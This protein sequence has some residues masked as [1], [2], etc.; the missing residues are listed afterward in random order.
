MRKKE[1]RKN[2]KQMLQVR[3]H[4]LKH[5][6]SLQTPARVIERTRHLILAT[7]TPAVIKVMILHNLQLK[8]AKRQVEA[9]R[10][11]KRKE[12]LRKLRPLAVIIRWIT[13]ILA[14]VMYFPPRSQKLWLRVI[15][16]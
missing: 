2:T 13:P 15:N 7:L 3:S 12:S 8:P 9:K 6:L 4:Q 14:L 5:Q 10:K 16:Q 11:N 1:A